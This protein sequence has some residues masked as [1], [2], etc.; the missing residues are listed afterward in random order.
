MAAEFQ[1][2]IV[3]IDSTINQT[4]DPAQ[5][6]ALVG[7]RTQQLV[8]EQIDLAQHP[9]VSWAV[10]PTSPASGGWKRAAVI[11]LV[12]GLALG[13][14]LAYVRVTRRQGLH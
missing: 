8:N 14:A 5:R 13:A 2:T 4:T 6:A 12:I 3:G 7:E 9:T 10:E 11:G 1:N